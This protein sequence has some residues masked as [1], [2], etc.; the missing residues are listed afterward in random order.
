MRKEFLSK[1]K[2]RKKLPHF[3]VESLLM[4]CCKVEIF[5][6]ARVLFVMTGVLPSSLLFSRFS[7]LFLLA[8]TAFLTN[9][10]VCCFRGVIMN[11]S[12]N[13]VRKFYWKWETHLCLGLALAH[14]LV[15]RQ[16]CQPVILPRDVAEILIILHLGWSY[17]SGWSENNQQ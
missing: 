15:Q 7:T 8:R 4:G 3:E 14:R 10:G 9:V 17:S 6:V 12:L 11:T 2:K 1:K 16:Q 5:F 13:Q